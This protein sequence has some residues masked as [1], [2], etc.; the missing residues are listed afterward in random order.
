MEKDAN[1][2]HKD[3]NPFGIASENLTEAEN[4]EQELHLMNKIYC[5]GYMLHQH[6]RESESF[7]VIGTDYKGGNSVKG[8][9][10]GTGKSFF[11]QWHSQNAKE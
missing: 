2:A 8:S 7:I 5:V 4:Y 3:L 1:E 11:G 9:Y 6:K 10:G